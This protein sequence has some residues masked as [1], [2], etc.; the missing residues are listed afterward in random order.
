MKTFKKG[1][2]IYYFRAIDGTYETI[3]ARVD[4]VHKASLTIISGNQVMRVSQSKCELQ[5]YKP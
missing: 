4:K 3:P 2:Y 5:N 1:D